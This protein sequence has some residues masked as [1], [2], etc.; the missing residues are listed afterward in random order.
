[1]ERPRAEII[2]TG[3][4][5][6]IAAQIEINAPARRIFDLLADPAMHPVIDGSG[7]VKRLTS[8]PKRL[9]LGAKFGMAMQVKLPYRITNEVVTFEEDK[10]IAWRH[11]MRWE[12]RYRLT[13]LDDNKT[14]VREEFDA[15]PSRS[16][17]WLAFTGAL[18]VNPK[19]MAKTLV[20]LKEHLER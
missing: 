12:W 11:F 10:E 7:S 18:K 13:P 5:L 15:R 8:G 3:I 14:L 9:Y 6:L 2:D 4:P 1:M 20:R 16:Q 17:R 19:L